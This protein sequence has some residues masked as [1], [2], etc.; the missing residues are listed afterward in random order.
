MVKAEVYDSLEE[1]Y[2][3]VTPRSEIRILELIF[4]QTVTHQLILSHFKR[5]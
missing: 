5:V 1:D 2:L 3:F 4:A